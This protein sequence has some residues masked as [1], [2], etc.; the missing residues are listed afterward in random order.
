M[1][2]AEDTEIEPRIARIFLVP[3]LHLRTGVVCEVELRAHVRSQVQLG[4]EENEQDE[5]NI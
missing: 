3:K 1:A 4:N 5:E 2:E